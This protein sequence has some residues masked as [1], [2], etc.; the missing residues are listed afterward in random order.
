MR[1]FLV[2]TWESGREEPEKDGKY[3]GESWHQVADGWSKCWRAEID[4]CI[5]HDLRWTPPA[6][7][8]TK[9][10]RLKIETRK[11]T[12]KNEKILGLLHWHI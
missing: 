3:E 11:E 4:A 12:N 5:P 1:V 8:P 7:N 2:T 9:K 10:F 6:P